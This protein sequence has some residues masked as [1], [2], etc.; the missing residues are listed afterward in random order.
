MN[1]IGSDR[2][3]RLSQCATNLSCQG[4]TR[5]EFRT[6][7]I[8]KSF[9]GAKVRKKTDIGSIVGVKNVERALI[10][11]CIVFFFDGATVRSPNARPTCLFCVISGLLL[12]YYCVIALGFGRA[13]AVVVHLSF[14]LVFQPECLREKVVALLALS[15]VSRPSARI[16]SAK[17][18]WHYSG[19][20][21]RMGRIIRLFRFPGLSGFSS[22]LSPYRTKKAA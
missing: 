8:A 13:F 4:K 18:P 12:C 15:S 10:Y 6:L 3:L 20:C 1:L 19:T 11:V 16:Q 9:S 5:E 7:L 17:V 21:F 14:I 2:L 22:V